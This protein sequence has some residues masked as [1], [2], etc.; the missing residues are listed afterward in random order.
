MESEHPPLPASGP[1]T[2]HIGFRKTGTTTLQRNLFAQHPDLVSLGKPE[3][4]PTGRALI[5]FLTNPEASV[6]GVEPLRRRWIDTHGEPALAGRRFVLS[7]EA[8]THFSL[9]R[10]GIESPIADLMQRIF[11]EARIMITIRNQIDLVESAYIHK[12]KRGKYRRLD[13]FLA[14]GRG[15]EVSVLDFHW[16]AEYYAR[17]FGRA[18]VGVFPLEQLAQ[19]PAAYARDVAAFLGIDAERTLALLGRSVENRRKSQREIVYVAL[20]SY[21]PVGALAHRLPGWARSGFARFLGGGR[22]A[23]VKLPERWRE[24]V[25]EMHAAANARLIDDYGVD[26]QRYGYA[27]SR[28]QG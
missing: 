9:Y 17:R 19:D 24:A 21:L 6:S 13:E 4:G 22:P 14:S 28:G 23:G 3:P 20:R 2:I 12:T 7:S 18:R 16:M 15:T 1:I 8:L 10:R 26:L 5:D 27:V 25:R 11:G